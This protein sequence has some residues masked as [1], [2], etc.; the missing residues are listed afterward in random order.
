MEMNETDSL[1]TSPLVPIRQERVTRT[2]H[3]VIRSGS[4]YQHCENFTMDVWMCFRRTDM[5]PHV[6][7][8]RIVRSEMF[9]SPRS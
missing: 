3:T 8:C 6:V 1:M 4:I 2:S 7:C 9:Y 5:E